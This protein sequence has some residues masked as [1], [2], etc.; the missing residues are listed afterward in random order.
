MALLYSVMGICTF[1]V[2][3]A[4]MLLGTAQIASAVTGGAISRNAAITAMTAAFVIYGWRGAGCDSRHR[5]HPGAA[6]CCDVALADPVRSEG[7]GVS[8][9]FTGLSTL[10]TS[11]FR[12]GGAYSGMILAAAITALISIVAQPHTWKCAQAKIRVRG[13]RRIHL[14]QHD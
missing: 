12:A 9:S 5:I 11:P 10:R 14:R 2:S 8:P 4:T 13:A 7:R 3:M 6:D 1:A